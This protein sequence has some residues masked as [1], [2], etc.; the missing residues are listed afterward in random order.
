MRSTIKSAMVLTWLFSA[1]GNVKCDHL[2]QSLTW[3]VFPKS[4]WIS[5]KDW[6]RIRSLL[7][8]IV[9]YVKDVWRFHMQYEKVA[10]LKVR[11]GSKSILFTYSSSSSSRG[12]FCSFLSWY[13]ICVTFHT[14]YINIILIF[15]LRSSTEKIVFTTLI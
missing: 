15:Y 12:I 2:H 8:S 11:I 9:P 13:I 1:D 5:I 14:H 3:D 4:W 10:T 7:I 6:S